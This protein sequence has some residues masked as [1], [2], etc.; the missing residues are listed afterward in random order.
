MRQFLFIFFNSLFCIA[1]SSEH[2]VPIV[3]FGKTTRESS[4]N[5]PLI[6]KVVLNA[7]INAVI[8]I[9]SHY[10]EKIL[11]IK[12]NKAVLD[13]MT[14]HENTLTFGKKGNYDK[15]DTLKMCLWL[16]LTDNFYICCNDNSVVV[17]HGDFNVLHISS[18]H[19]ARVTLQGTAQ[20]LW[21][22]AKSG[23]V[24]D[25]AEKFKAEHA[26]VRSF[27]H[28]DIHVQADNV[29]ME[30]RALG[31]IVYYGNAK[32]NKKDIFGDAKIYKK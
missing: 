3:L 13:Q 20:K 11:K 21:L 25:A 23:S 15:Q 14:F 2:R 5:S 29:Y 31:T 32:I 17:A 22:T 9:G 8:R 27:D 19:N 10:K 18:D 30:A 4:E 6:K 24:I 26:T 7:A 1:T 28:S 16:A 12:G